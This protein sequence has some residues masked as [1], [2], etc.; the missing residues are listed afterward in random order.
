MSVVPYSLI[1]GG[2][3]E[4]EKDIEKNKKE[5][6]WEFWRQLG[7]KLSRFGDSQLS[8]SGDS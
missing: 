8:R 2:D 3:I 4:R 6:V 7:G 1:I 5:T